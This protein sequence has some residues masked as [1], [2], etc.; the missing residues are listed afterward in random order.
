MTLMRVTGYSHPL[1]RNSSKGAATGSAFLSMFFLGTG[2]AIV[3]AT[4][5]A[6]GLSASQ[7]GYL[8]AAQNIGFGVAVVW[9]GALSDL[10]PKPVILTAGLA[11]LAVSFAL[12]YRAGGFGLNLAVMFL[13]GAGM[14]GVEAVT[15]A[16]LLDMHT[17]NESRYVTINH[18]FVSVG[19]VSITV[20]LMM[21]ELN[22]RA[23]LTQVAVAVG[24]LAVIVAFIRPPSRR[25][26]SSGA[27]IVREL[28]S[29][30]GILLMF[31]AGAGAIGLGAG[32]TGVITTYATQVRSMNVESAQI[33]LALFLVGLAAGRILIGALARHTR[34]ARIATVACA[35]AFVCSVVLFLTPVS[36]PVLMALA[37]VLGFCV[38]PLLPLT[39]ATAG[40]RY[41]H[42]AGAAMGMVKLAIPVGGIV[43]PGLLGLITDLVS[44]EAAL[45]LL[46]ASA[47]LF[48]VATGLGAQRRTA[49]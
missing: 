25:G 40:L 34:P 21:L 5:Q 23:S 14:G 17:R 48:L 39:I 30:A 12:L 26:A 28:T 15:D 16:M 27:Q 19:M 13:M 44:F 41:R 22:W 10:Y 37:A 11:V 18:F 8:I 20:Y 45:Y 33:A 46:P 31:C 1:M 38:A 36:G 9:A 6:V 7:I 49:I 35:L 47:L 43:F 3:G 32:V 4:A 42:A 29:D 2:V 24:A